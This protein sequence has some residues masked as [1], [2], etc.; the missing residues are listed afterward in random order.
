MLRK[1]TEADAARVREAQAAIFGATPATDRRDDGSHNWLRDKCR[2]WL[3]RQPGVCVWNNDAAPR[4]G[5]PG[6]SDLIGWRVVSF[7]LNGDSPGEIR[8]Y[9]S[10]PQFV[11][12]EIKRGRDK[13]RVKQSGFLRDLKAANG[14]AI[15]V[16]DSLD[17]L[18]RKWKEATR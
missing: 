10:I 15:T 13:E 3:N 12:I 5:T 14:I 4:H 8:M 9:E 18:R 11:G 17:D 1:F 6:T 16:R 7:C 2:D